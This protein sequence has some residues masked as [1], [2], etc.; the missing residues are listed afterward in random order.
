[1]ND[2]KYCV[3]KHTSPSGKVY[4]G[5]TGVKPIYRWDNGK[6][7]D[8][9]PAFYNAI[10]KYGWDNIDHE[11][12]M[13]GLSCK[14]AQEAE[15]RLIR[16]YQSTNKKRGYNISAG[17]GGTTGFRHSEKMRAE[18]SQR[19]RGKGHP[20]YGKKFSEESK[21]KMSESHKGIRLSETTR[22]KM[23]EVRTGE[24]NWRS[25]KVFQYTLDGCFVAEHVSGTAA[26]KSAGCSQTAISRC[27]CGK[28]KTIY[29][30]I[31]RYA[32]EQERVSA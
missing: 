14:E 11:I 4:I 28:A 1:M 18:M 21:R 12:L 31:W 15:I 19:I 13:T 9:S 23:S 2:R 3:Y 32:D 25:R 16:E 7:Y 8:D 20:M 27:C 17:G 22:Q 5:I 30:F 10:M 6:G 26:A 29:G 24:G